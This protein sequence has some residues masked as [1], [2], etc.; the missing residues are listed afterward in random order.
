MDQCLVAFKSPQMGK[1]LGMGPF[2]ITGV[3]R[4]SSDGEGVGDGALREL[5]RKRARA[6]EGWVGACRRHNH[7]QSRD[8]WGDVAGREHEKKASE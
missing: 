1:G 3:A 7:V 8:G 4:Q 5:G 6:V 2:G